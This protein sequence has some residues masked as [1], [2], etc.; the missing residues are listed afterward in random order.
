MNQQEIEADIRALEK[1]ADWLDSRFAI[2]GTKYRI[3]LDGLIGFIPVI[4]DSLTTVISL[5]ILRKAFRY[6]LPLHIKVR[7]LWN[8]FY[9]WLIGLIPFIGDILDI[10]FK[11]NK[12]NV[13]LLKAYLERHY[14]T[15]KYRS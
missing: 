12:K 5:Y 2:P 13:A 10:R 9:D 8:S 4:G 1:L 14:R 6:K 3:G 7:M 15:E 11:A